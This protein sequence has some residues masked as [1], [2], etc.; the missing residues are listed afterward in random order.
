MMSLIVQ[1]LCIIFAVQLIAPVADDLGVQNIGCYNGPVN[2]PT[3]DQPADKGTRFSTFY[4]GCTV[5][6]PS[7]ATLL[8]GRHH[9]RVGVYSWL[10]D[11]LQKSH[12]LTREI[13][14]AEVLKDQGYA[15]GHFGSA[16]IRLLVCYLEQ[17]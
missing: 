9:I 16:R 10:R 7:R 12:L 17:C 5:W 6:S 4:S 3:L 8:T 14:L 11:E 2:T 13:T 15:T 1:V